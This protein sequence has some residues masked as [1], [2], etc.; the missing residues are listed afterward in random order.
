MDWNRIWRPKGILK[1]WAIRVDLIKMSDFLNFFSALIW[2]FSIV[3]N[4][5]NVVTETSLLS[6]FSF[7]LFILAYLVAS[8]GSDVTFK[9]VVLVETW[10]LL[11]LSCTF[12][13][14]QKTLG[15]M[16]FSNLVFLS[17]TFL[18]NL[19]EFYLK[20]RK[21]DGVGIRVEENGDT[22][23]G[24]DNTAGEALLQE[25]P[26]E[27][28][29][30]SN[31]ALNEVPNH[32]LPTIATVELEDRGFTNLD[33]HSVC[34]SL[35]CTL[36]ILFAIILFQKDVEVLKCRPKNENYE[37][38]NKN[39][40]LRFVLGIYCLIGGIL[41]INRECN[42]SRKD[43]VNI[44]NLFFAVIGTVIVIFT[45]W[46][47]FS[48]PM[49]GLYNYFV[50][51]S[52][53]LTAMM[54]MSCNFIGLVRKYR[55]QTNY[56]FRYYT[57]TD[58]NPSPEHS[59]QP[60]LPPQ[61]PLDLVIE[62]N[63]GASHHGKAITIQKT[64][65]VDDDSDS[66]IASN[67]QF[68]TIQASFWEDLRNLL[69]KHTLLNFD[70]GFQTVLV[71][72]DLW[73]IMTPILRGKSRYIDCL[74]IFPSVYLL[75]FNSPLNFFVNTALILIGSYLLITDIVMIN[76]ATPSLKQRSLMFLGIAVLHYNFNY[77]FDNY[78]VIE[79][80]YF[81]LACVFYYVS[82]TTTK[83][84]FRAIWTL[85]FTEDGTISL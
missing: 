58:H 12:V 57:I 31:D 76:S 53:S 32:N 74:D 35:F 49:N 42:R 72:S 27:T 84:I 51:A 7:T 70:V 37:T 82:R 9:K 13:I 52:V 65:I 22:E 33:L 23:V 26:Q 6:E 29:T 11:A 85:D 75:E 2:A 78:T 20:Y 63:A 18:W 17:V 60:E 47:I 44:F 59:A 41:T 3:I 67:I 79:R 1:N 61:D 4:S 54:L 73:L 62:L 30:S 8:T 21:L 81:V 5:I 46:S 83:S 16:P 15:G 39:T 24:Q 10:I 66:S 34:F 25:H 77:Y 40:V 19:I 14:V 71:L 43:G 45:D 56:E 50:I 36:P 55:H 48:P 68:D 38:Q 64:A 80:S 69:Q 28:A